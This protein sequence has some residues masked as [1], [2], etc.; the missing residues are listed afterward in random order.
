LLS[1]I[2]VRGHH[3]VVLAMALVIGSQRLLIISCA[4]WCETSHHAPAD[5][6]THDAHGAGQHVSVPPDGVSA[7][8]GCR[9]VFSRFRPGPTQVVA[10]PAVTPTASAIVAPP[11][12]AVPPL[13]VA[14]LAADHAPPVLVLRI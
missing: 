5:A 13:S 8:D 1:W 9:H 11:S 7:S 4:T 12:T 3:V 6:S 2:A 10:Q 14:R